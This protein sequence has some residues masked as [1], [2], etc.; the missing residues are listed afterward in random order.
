[1]DS[2]NA[3]PA[4]EPLLHRD[5]GRRLRNLFGPAQRAGHI[6]GVLLIAAFAA[7]MFTGGPQRWGLS[8][9]AL[10][11]GR[12]ETLLTSMVSHAGLIHLIVNLSALSTFSAR[13]TPHLGF[14]VRGGWLYAVL[15][16]LSGLAGGLMFLAV[17]PFGDI[18]MVGI[19]GA[20]CGLWGATL[21]LPPERGWA[22]APLVSRQVAWGARQFAISNAIIFAIIFALVFLSGGGAGGLAWEAHLGG[23]LFGL[24]AVPLFVRH[25]PLP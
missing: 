12:F 19:S 5:V 15:L 3:P 7:E 16:G 13:L 25:V 11:D 18:P 10:A 4:R 1:M 24:L 21:R 23:F 20:I 9:A 8:A 6:T 22:L 14:G 2:P 17:H